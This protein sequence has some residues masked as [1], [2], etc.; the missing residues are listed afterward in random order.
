MIDT[1]F[2]QAI[3]SIYS[4]GVEKI[5]SINRYKVSIEYLIMMLSTNIEGIYNKKI[6]C[7][8]KVKMKSPPIK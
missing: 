5:V 2:C 4:L 6:F 1:Y 7:Y 3:T 8:K